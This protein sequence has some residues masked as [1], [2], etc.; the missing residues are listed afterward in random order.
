MDRVKEK[1]R[2]T[3]SI[4]RR[5]NL[6][7]SIRRAAHPRQPPPVTTQIDFSQPPA[8]DNPFPNPF[9]PYPSTLSP[10]TLAPGAPQFTTPIPP[11]PTW[12]ESSHGPAISALQPPRLYV[13]A[14]ALS[15]DDGLQ[16]SFGQ[17]RFNKE[18]NVGQLVLNNK[19]LSCY[20][21]DKMD[22]DPQDQ[23][24]LYHFVD[25]VLPTIF[26]I[27]DVHR[28]GPSRAP[29]LLNKLE[30]N[31]AYFFTCLSV[32]ALHVKTTLNVDP[33]AVDRD[34]LQHRYRAVA[35]L[36]TLMHM[37]NGH[38]KV[39]DT[40]LGMIIL[41]CSV[42]ETDDYLPDIP[43]FEHLR[44]ISSLVQ[45]LKLTEYL[46]RSFPPLSITLASWIDILGGTM[47]GQSPQLAH[48][49]RDRH[50]N[51]TAIGLQELMGCEDRVMFLISEIA[52]LEG[53]KKRDSLRR[54][55]MRHHIGA[56]RAQIDH[57]E[58]EDKTLRN[59]C[60]ATGVIDWDILT[61]NIT[62][63]F[64]VA[65][66]IY[67]YSLEPG[68][69]HTQPEITSLVTIVAETL[70]FIPTG[71]FGFDRSLAWPLFMTG[72]HS[73]P[74][75][76]F[77][78]ILAQRSI[79]LGPARASGSF[80]RMY[81]IVQEV[82]RLSE[83]PITLPGF[84]DPGVHL[85]APGFIPIQPEAT[86]A[87][88][89]TFPSSGT[90]LPPPNFNQMQPEVISANQSAY[91]LPSMYLPSPDFNQ[92]QLPSISPMPQTFPESGMYLPSPGLNQ[93]TALP[94]DH[95]PYMG[96]MEEPNKKELV[97]WRDVMNANEWHYLLI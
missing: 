82:W 59:P 80:G 66:R 45:K 55:D 8:Y 92:P 51:G 93:G 31:R 10:S 22:V 26:P 89:A 33:A 53:L 56:L 16:G 75:C 13:P 29:E 88:A 47:L 94:P 7:E 15:V 81:R 63:M 70:R 17:P 74:N 28:E 30:T 83:A 68:F 79:A 91:P 5:R 62:T 9:V 36:S 23:P 96:T 67:L 58:P 34:I 77:R 38:A 46:P 72:V 32:S 73:T 69:D 86:S 4:E 50:I 1:I 12:P 64:R 85:P 48:E 42:G 27:I 18:G 11:A 25:F 3:K 43:W 61:K 78:D 87:S 19:P 35:E 20:L 57:A 84:H 44:S 40:I 41:Y 37:D 39:L 95:M 90:Y 60:S 2:E 24:L 65:A 71:P 76:A 54:W 21:E 14:P 97:H 6:E 49:F 52:C